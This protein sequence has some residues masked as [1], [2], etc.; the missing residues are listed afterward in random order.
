MKTHWEKSKGDHQDYVELHDTGVL[1][2]SNEG[3]MAS[4]AAGICSYADFLDGRFQD[5]I[6]RAFGE[7][8]LAEIVEAVK[9]RYT[10][11]ATASEMEPPA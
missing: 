4:D 9:L 5:L 2:G 10:P 3:T 7:R 1:V 8:V 11:S 6:L